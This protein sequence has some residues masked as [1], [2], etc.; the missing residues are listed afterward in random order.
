MEKVVAP[1]KVNTYQENILSFLREKREN[2][3]VQAVAGSGK[4]TT[5]VASLQATVAC[6]A[7]FLA[8][9]KAIAEELS[10]K[11]PTHFQAS[12]IH[13]LAF[14]SFK[15]AGDWVKINEKKVRNL[16]MY[17]L[18]DWDKASRETKAFFWEYGQDLLRVVAL[19]K[20]NNVQAE[21][22][23]AIQD[24]A[25]RHG[26]DLLPEHIEYVQK[27]LELSRKQTKVIDFEDMIGESIRRGW[28]KLIPF[29]F[30]AVDE[31]QDLNPLQLLFLQ[32]ILKP[33]GRLLAVGDKYQSIYGFRGADPLSMQ[34][35]QETF[36]CK[37]LPLSLSYRCSQAV[38]LEAKRFC[39]QIEAL[40][41][42]PVG[43]VKREDYKEVLATIPTGS[44]ILCRI[45]APL[46]SCCI[47]LLAA[48]KSARILGKETAENLLAT[49]QQ[50]EQSHGLST[51]G[52]DSFENT[53]LEKF[54]AKKQKHKADAFLD[55]MDSIRILLSKIKKEAIPAT[56]SRLFS[57]SG[58]G[59][60]LSTIHKAKGLEAE[61]VYILRPEILPWPKAEK[62]WEKQQERNLCYVAITRAKKNL[63]YVEEA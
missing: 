29:D 17:D 62:D 23:S 39:P 33:G 3:L 4:T 45:N 25:D 26:L 19:V 37:E 57:D 11:V 15:K 58:N 48:G 44:R 60:T 46:L 2:V 35:I 53:K 40:P 28:T 1:N 55:M 52:L 36:S 20:N 30:L 27:L 24:L 38:V 56:L 54:R 59:I 8:F 49:I 51:S 41:N 42:A 34:R 50:I 18:L 13:S 32:R 22:T 63:V 47:D 21:D 6:Q 43:T 7:A 16:F 9:N 31:S 12:T 61:D 14:S 5:L 10:S